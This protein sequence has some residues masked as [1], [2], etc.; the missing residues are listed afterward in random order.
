MALAKFIGTF[1]GSGGLMVNRFPVAPVQQVVTVRSRMLRVE[2]SPDVLDAE[3]VVAVALH[4]QSEHLLECLQSIDAQVDLGTRVA[5]VILDDHSTDAWRTSIL[6]VPGSIPRMILE[7]TIGSVGVVRNVLLDFVDSFLPKA[8]WVARLDADDRLACPNSLSGMIQ[9]GEGSG[10][11]YVLGGNRLRL[12]GAMLDRCNR[13]VP[14]LMHSSYVLSRLE[15][16]ADGDAGA[17]LP[18]CNLAIRT[19]SEWRYPEDESGEDHWLVAELLL[20]HSASGVLVEDP[21]YADYTLSGKTTL[22]HQRSG[23][24]LASRRRLLEQARAWVRK[25]R[26]A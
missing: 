9:A 4:N 6:A 3:V 10:A 16:M 11:R 26:G 2:S 1:L 18:S 14:E 7:G 12:G 15:G 22:R 17:E 19:G 24:Y 23:R 21:F 8:R 20:R 5:I 13:A 25:G